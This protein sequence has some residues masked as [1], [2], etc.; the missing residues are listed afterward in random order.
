MEKFNQQKRIKKKKKKKQTWLKLESH[1]Q[2]LSKKGVP[3]SH[4]SDIFLINPLLNIY[5]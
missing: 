2:A 1:D 5:F 4:Q 3:N